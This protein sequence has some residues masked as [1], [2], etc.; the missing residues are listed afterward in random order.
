[1]S[2]TFHQIWLHY[3]RSTKDRQNFINSNLK[4]ELISHIKEYGKTNDIYV[5]TINGYRDHLHLLIKM[6]P[7]QSPSQLAKLLKGES[8]NWINHKDFLKM[9]FSWQNG[10]GV[11]SISESQLEN[12]RQYILNQEIHHKKMTYKQEVDKFVKTYGIKLQTS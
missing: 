5:D 9:K 6:K 2:Q 11:F 12:V 1:M 8:S 10:Y 7:N 4:K 3:I